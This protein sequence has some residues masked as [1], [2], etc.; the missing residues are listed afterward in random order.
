[1][2]VLEKLFLIN[3]EEPERVFPAYDDMRVI[4]LPSVFFENIMPILDGDSVKVYL[5]MAYLAQMSPWLHEAV[6]FKPSSESLV[7][8]IASLLRIDCNTVTKALDTLYSLGLVRL[9]PRYAR[10]SSKSTDW[11][12]KMD[13][14]YRL[15]LPSVYVLELG[16]MRLK[17]IVNENAT[18]SEV[19]ATAVASS[20][21]SEQNAIELQALITENFK[22]AQD[23]LVAIGAKEMRSCEL[24]LRRYGYGP[25]MVRVLLEYCV[26]LGKADI[27]YADS[28]AREWH[29]S[30]I[31]TTSDVESYLEKYE[32]TR[33]RYSRIRKQMGR[34]DSLT[35]DEKDLYDKWTSTWNF[36]EDMVFAACKEATKAR[37]PSFAYL[38]SVL[39]TW[40]E[41]GINTLEG[42][43]A[44]SAKHKAVRATML[45]K[46][47]GTSVASRRLK[48]DDSSRRSE[49]AKYY[50]EYARLEE[51]ML[52]SNNKKA[53][54]VV[55]TGIDSNSETAE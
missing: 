2:E 37:T 18:T 50:G 55:P 44:H 39:N 30:G 26:S 46:G 29:K 21:I 6:D 42:I 17:A 27:R 51:E 20:D 16:A 1:M 48:P 31:K 33:G 23:V 8:R 4:T 49:A 35:Q 32:E 47:N 9:K 14:V 38:D 53:T 22:V 54:Q 13:D 24:W 45:K 34:H 28:V 15:E 3:T 40:R 43:A 19:A 10:D 25:D 11:R 5:C 41:S 12:W 7:E 36:S 52:D